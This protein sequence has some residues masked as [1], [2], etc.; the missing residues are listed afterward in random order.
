MQFLQ[1][2]KIEIDFSESTTTD[3]DSTW[4]CL[5][6][7]ILSADFFL[8]AFRV[9]PIHEVSHAAVFAYTVLINS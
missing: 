6:K 9:P 7:D 5:I 4:T 2:K 1:E 8:H 3:T